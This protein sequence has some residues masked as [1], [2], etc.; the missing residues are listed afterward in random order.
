MAKPA[1]YFKN[2]KDEKILKNK[3]QRA[4]KEIREAT[5]EISKLMSYSKKGTLHTRM[6][7]SGLKKLSNHFGS[8]PGHFPHKP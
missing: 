4:K 7:E 6:L 8:I 1:R 5:Q 2:V 3:V